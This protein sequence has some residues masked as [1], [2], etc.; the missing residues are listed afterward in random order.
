MSVQ[1]LQSFCLPVILYG[2]KVTEPQKSVLTMLNN[3][4][5][6]AVSDKDVICHIRQ[7][8]GLH[9]IDV[10]CKERHERFLRRSGSL[11][12][13]VVHSLTAQYSFYSLI[14]L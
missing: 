1:L 14:F 7:C 2:L 6:R 13:A 3:L 4:I 11:R 9:D 5:N 12:H 10:L 8:P